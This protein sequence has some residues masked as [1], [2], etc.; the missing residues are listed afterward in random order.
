MNGSED[1]SP[2]MAPERVLALGWHDGATPGPAEHHG[3]YTGN[4]EMIVAYLNA[5]ASA[6]PASSAL[7]TPGAASPIRP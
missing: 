7:A 4:S 2:S 3:D 1:T 5:T 6:S